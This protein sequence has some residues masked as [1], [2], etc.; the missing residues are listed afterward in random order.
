MD[1]YAHAVGIPGGSEDEPGADTEPS[2]FSREVGSGFKSEA[3]TGVLGRFLYGILSSGDTSLSEL[4][5][6]IGE[7]GSGD[8]SVPLAA[9]DC[10]FSL[11]GADAGGLV[12]GFG[13][14]I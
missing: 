7:E 5:K 6:T 1:T 13:L 8:T 2:F 12:V 11:D 9:L 3:S 10:S 4:F 14:T